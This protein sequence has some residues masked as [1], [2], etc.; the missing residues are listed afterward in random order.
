[1]TVPTKPVTV[2]CDIA[3]TVIGQ[4]VTMTSQTLCPSQ[5]LVDLLSHFSLI[6]KKKSLKYSLGILFT[7]SGSFLPRFKLGRGQYPPTTPI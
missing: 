4:P 1:M 6:F 7:I 3:V 2:A 5:V